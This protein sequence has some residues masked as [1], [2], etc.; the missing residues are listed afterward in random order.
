MKVGVIGA[1]Y[2]GKK[3]VEE[4]RALG[5]EVVV[6]DL[7]KKNLAICKEKYNTHVTN[8][9][10]DIISD[11]EIACV[12][13]CTPNQTHYPIGKQALLAGKNVLLE[14]P[15]T[16]KS[17]DADELV[18]LAKKKGLT[19][20]VGHLFRF[21][22][23]VRKAKELLQHRE[24]G[25]IYLVKLSWTNLEPIFVGRDVVF[26][27][28]PHAFDMINFLFEKNPLYLSYYGAGFR[29]EQ[30]EAA[31]ISGKISNILLHLEVSWV[32]PD[33]ARLL[34]IIGSKKMLQA[35]CVKQTLRLYD[36][37]TKSWTDVPIVANN[38]LREELENFLN[39]AKMKKVS[40]VDGKVGADIIRVIESMKKPEL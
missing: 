11:P 14:K 39:C 36:I 12:S 38:T 19:L 2:W 6:A 1:G 21:A 26:D 15:M 33:K 31:F 8:N 20:M 34:T 35:E 24:L 23:V 28:T 4:Y 16:L 32:T 17:K 29:Q 9:M 25:E 13:I 40:I 7:D 5:V 27:L 37:Q 22:N 18:N 30:E 10:N 3:H